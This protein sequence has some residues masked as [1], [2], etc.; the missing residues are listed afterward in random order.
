VA[1]HDIAE[2][3]DAVQAVDVAQKRITELTDH[4]AEP[5]SCEARFAP[6]YPLVFVPTGQ[7][8][9]GRLGRFGQRPGHRTRGSRARKS[10]VQRNS[11]STCSGL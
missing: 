4:A 11:A 6:V 7:M 3:R 1:G 9:Q 5:A 2:V 8:A 10:R